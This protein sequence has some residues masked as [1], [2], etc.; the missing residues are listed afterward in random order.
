MAALF[1]GVLPP[2]GDMLEGAVTLCTV[3]VPAGLISPPA[4]PAPDGNGAV[5]LQA[6]LRAIPELDEE[7]PVPLGA[8]L[9]GAALKLA[10]GQVLLEEIEKALD[11]KVKAMSGAARAELAAALKR[12]L[13]DTKRTLAAEHPGTDPSTLPAYTKERDR[14]VNFMRKLGV[15]A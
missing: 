8:T 7:Q 5:T 11:A 15:T 6:F 14:V 12:H 13:E 9:E 4:F 2:R 3:A 1:S 10:Y